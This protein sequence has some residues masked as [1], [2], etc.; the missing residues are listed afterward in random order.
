MAPGSNGIP[1]PAVALQRF[2]NL[3]TIAKVGST[4]T[5]VM[6]SPGL[7]DPATRRSSLGGVYAATLN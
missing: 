6:G 4:T 3:A 1:L 7:S 5:F 2:A